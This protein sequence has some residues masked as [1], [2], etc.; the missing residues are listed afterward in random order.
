MSNR[1]YFNIF[2]NNFITIQKWTYKH[3]VSKL[4][5]QTILH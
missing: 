2:F 5:K 3:K 1:N 4:L